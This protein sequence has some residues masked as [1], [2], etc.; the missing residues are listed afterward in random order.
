MDEREN[1]EEDRRLRALRN[2]EPLDEIK[3][4]AQKFAR[5]GESSLARKAY[6]WRVQA[7]EVLSLG[8]P[9]KTQI[10]ES[11]AITLTEEDAYG[12]QQP[13]DNAF[14]VTMSLTNYV[15]HWIFFDNGSL[16]NI[17]YWPT[18]KQMKLGRSA[19]GGARP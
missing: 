2:Q 8:R 14:V 16:T 11:W 19:G 15:T 6:T 13:H 1:W 4:I 18:F 10:T 17:L 5:R 9:S 3:T 12:V 7:E